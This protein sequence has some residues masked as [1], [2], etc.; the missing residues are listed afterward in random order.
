MSAI[1]TDTKD[2]VMV[3]SLALSL[4]SLILLF[5]VTWH[6]ESSL[7]HLE[8]QVDYDRELFMKQNRVRACIAAIPNA[9]FK[10]LSV[11]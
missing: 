3:V 4:V 11:M 9:I 5:G 2:V 7:N 6:F 10:L 1:G 8:H